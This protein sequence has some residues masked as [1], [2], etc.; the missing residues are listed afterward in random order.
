M[1]K[2]LITVFSVSVTAGTLYLAYD[3]LKRLQIKKLVEACQ[4]Q[5]AEKNKA[6]EP[7]KLKEELDKLFLWDLRLLAKITERVNRRPDA[8]LKKLK[9][10]IK[11]KGLLEKANLKA[12]EDL[13][14]T[15]T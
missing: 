6:F 5:A 12:F 2:S 13:I 11:T 14:L 9:E 15:T 8:E 7:N 10:K 1:K 4:R 3:Q